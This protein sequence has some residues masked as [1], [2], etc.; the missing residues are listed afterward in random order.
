M[1]LSTIDRVKAAEQA[2][3]EAREN[4]ELKAKAIVDEAQT[5]ADNMI[6]QAKAKALDDEQAQASAA[7]SE[8][9]A[10]ILERRG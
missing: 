1:A 5:D 6:A 10:K 3:N 2:A 9:Q 7:Q 4:A 8:A